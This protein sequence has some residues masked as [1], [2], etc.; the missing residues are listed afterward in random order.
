MVDRR[1]S[2]SHAGDVRF[3]DESVVDDAL[4]VASIPAVLSGFGDV[5]EQVEPATWLDGGAKLGALDAAETDETGFFIDLLDQEAEQLSG[6]FDLN[7]TWH[8]RSV[9]DVASNPEFVVGDILEAQDRALVFIG[10]EDTVEVLH[11]ETL[12]I[13]PADGFLVIYR[14]GV[15][16]DLGQVK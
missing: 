15:Q 6:R 9:R 16:I 14:L 4:D 8:E 10:P 11:L 12:R 13:D 1:S 3:E 2:D 5:S 7:D